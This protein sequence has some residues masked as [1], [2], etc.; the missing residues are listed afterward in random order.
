MFHDNTFCVIGPPGCGKTTSIEKSVQKNIPVYGR[1][2]IVVCSLTRSAAAVAA[3]R[4][5]LDRQNIGTLHAFAFRALGSPDITEK[6]LKD[7]NEEH[8]SLTIGTAGDMDDQTID[9]RSS[10]SNGD[11]LLADYGLLRARC[12]PR[13]LWPARVASFARLWDD[14][15]ACTGTLDFTDLIEFAARDTMHCPGNPDVIYMDE[16]QDSSKL[17]SELISTWSARIA[18][19][20][21]VGDPNQS[22]F[23]W[24]GASPETFFPTDLPTERIHR[25]RQ[26]Y[27]VPAEVLHR[28]LT[29]LKKMPGYNSE[30]YNPTPH[31]GS[32]TEH[33]AAFAPTALDIAARCQDEG[34]TC[35]IIASCGYMLNDLIAGLR[36]AGLPF[37]NPYRRRNGAWN[38]LHGGGVTGREK[39]LSWLAPREDLWAWDARVWTAQD[40]R[41]W[42]GALKGVLNKGWKSKLAEIDS[43][44]GFIR[45]A[46]KPEALERIINQD[47]EWFRQNLTKQAEVSLNFPLRICDKLNP[48]TLADEPLIS[49]GTI[50]SVKGGEADCV[51]I[52]PELS[53][54]GWREYTAN[55]PSIY[56]LF[57]VALT[58]SRSEAHIIIDS[59][60]KRGAAI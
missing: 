47:F 9:T 46:F 11:N 24:R 36:E 18:K 39:I 20:V 43:V 54:S 7:W 50:H 23:E 44:I 28:A 33:Y 12:M 59:S 30:P 8:P 57:Y 37:H 1:D 15:K 10:A 38:P 19:T 6:K 14:F 41:N 52:S 13:E 25:L 40:V 16:A 42:A 2:R 26:S 48:T 58:R 31:K 4:V 51:V 49:I 32:V 17:E 35:M 56:R 45:E 29:W 5:G 55:H 60:G 34:K 53:Y 21:I 3:G 22:L 27:R